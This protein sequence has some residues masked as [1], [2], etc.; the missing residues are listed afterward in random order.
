MKTFSRKRQTGETYQHYSDSSST[1]RSKQTATCYECNIVFLDSNGLS[2]HRAALHGP[3]KAGPPTLIPKAG[4][5][6]LI[7]KKSENPQTV[8]QPIKT[9]NIV[10][11]VKIQKKI[12]P[13]KILPSPPPQNPRTKTEKIIFDK[14]SNGNNDDPDDDISDINNEFNEFRALP[15]CIHHYCGLCRISFANIKGY[16]AHCE[17]AKHHELHLPTSD[18]VYGDLICFNTAK[19]YHDIDDAKSHFCVNRTAA[20][21]EKCKYCIRSFSVQVRCKYYHIDN[22]LTYS[23]K[24]GIIEIYLQPHQHMKDHIR[25]EHPE[26]LEAKLKYMS[27]PSTKYPNYKSYKYPCKICG[28]KFQTMAEVTKHEE[29]HKT[30]IKSVSVKLTGLEDLSEPAVQTNIDS[31]DDNDSI[32]IQTISESEDDDEGFFVGQDHLIT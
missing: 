14:D 9:S 23:C 5:P 6:T 18:K 12:I 24:V 26:A 32:T 11:S 4:P 22:I 21:I 3:T 1:K 10:M 13:K 15:E 31:V 7:P 28:R 30:A 2:K 16:K 19:V 17:K 25:C 20:K 27:V 8:Q 29:L